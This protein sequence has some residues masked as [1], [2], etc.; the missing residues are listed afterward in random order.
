[1]FF[2]NPIHK[3]IRTIFLHRTHKPINAILSSKSNTSL[4]FKPHESWFIIITKDEIN[5]LLS[6]IIRILRRSK[7]PGTSSDSSVPM[8]QWGGY[9][10]SG[11][12]GWWESSNAKTGHF[13]L[14]NSLARFVVSST[15]F[16]ICSLCVVGA[17]RITRQLAQLAH[18]SNITNTWKTLREK[19][20]THTNFRFFLEKFE[21][22]IEK[23]DWSNIT[24]TWKAL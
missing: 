17:Y 8:I 2:L 3:D 18:W 1:M 4:T 19:K 22:I 12:S 16:D 23:Y 11:I 24:N 10:S 21:H 20:H 9:G 15:I 5:R 14:Q 6:Q 7:I 13:R